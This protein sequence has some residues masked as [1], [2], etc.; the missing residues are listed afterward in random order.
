MKN[1]GV[2]LM[3][4]QMYLLLLLIGS[5]D[6]DIQADEEDL[7]MD[8]LMER[9]GWNVDDS[10]EEEDRENEFDKKD[11][12][13][14]DNLVEA[15]EN[16][17]SIEKGDLKHEDNQEK[18]ELGHITGKETLGY[19]NS[20]EDS[21]SV[22]TRWFGFGTKRRCYCEIVS[23][24]SYNIPKQRL[25]IFETI[26]TKRMLFCTRR[27]KQF[28]RAACIR[29]FLRFVSKNSCLVDQLCHGGRYTDKPRKIG[30]HLS[31]RRCFRP[32][33]LWK[34]KYHV[35]CNHAL[36]SPAGIELFH[37]SVHPEVELHNSE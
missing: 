17:E 32:T 1:F 28:C 21:K 3:I 37:H 6:S 18:R 14:D 7:D 22:N 11:L 5:G 12:K 16:E 10:L 36:H 15:V 19:E 35:S 34:S 9:Y 29:N 4:W 27:V 20:V 2:P 13:G 26:K 31:T 25:Y 23:L 30:L 33:L 8:A 24:N